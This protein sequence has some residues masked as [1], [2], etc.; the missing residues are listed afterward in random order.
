MKK[1]Q[2]RLKFKRVKGLRD[3]TGMKL[4]GLAD[5]YPLQIESKLKG[6]KELE[7]Y[8]HEMLHY[9]YPNASEEVVQRNSIVICNTLWHEGFRKVDNS[10]CIPMQDGT[11]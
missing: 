7:I 5:V 2:T 4:H 9:I 8:L 6:K 3:D 10:N 1:T 11:L